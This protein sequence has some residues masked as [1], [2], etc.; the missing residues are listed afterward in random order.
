MT[1]HFIDGGWY[2]EYLPS[3]EWCAIIPHVECRT[4][5]GPVALPPGEAFGPGFVRCTNMD[6]FRFAGQAHDTLDP[7]GWEW[8][9]DGTWRAH[10]PP[11]VGVNPL[12]YDLNGMLHL[13]DGSVGSQGYRYVTPENVIV[14]GDATYR[15]AVGQT[16]I[17]EYT[18][19]GGLLIGQGQEGGVVVWDGAV[20][21]L[22]EP[23]DCRFIRANRANDVVA[24]AFT[25]PDGV[26]LMLTTMAALR[27][28]PPVVTPE[29]P[30]PTPVPPEPEP[31]PE[32]PLPPT[33][34]P[35]TPLPPSSPRHHRSLTMDLNGKI[36][37]LR[38]PA[39]KLAS[40]DAP[41]TGTW[42]SLGAGWRGIAWVD[43]HVTASA[44]HHRAAKV[45]NNYTFTSLAHNGLAGA[46]AT[47]HSGAIDQQFYY[48][49][50]GNTD[51]GGYETWRVYDGNEN[52]ALEAQ[53]EYSNDEGRYF[54]CRLAVEIVG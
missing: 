53:I 48:K 7:A 13:S 54:A 22:L 25:R 21:R 28:L 29:P 50:D 43:P 4:H 30:E 2:G 31:G 27:A 10:P 42:G 14:S 6:G 32:P 35:P 44:T 38:G 24:L 5:L 36:V 37:I 20:L 40:P 41:N 18:D 49:P 1:R 19:V 51:A 52:G 39:G 16:A 8:F 3:G 33:P 12:I 34:I 15:L 46:D 17:Y 47:K 9:A 11:C 23:G 45:G 26:V